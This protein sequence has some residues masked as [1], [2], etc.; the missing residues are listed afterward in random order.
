VRP[1]M[2][3]YIEAERLILRQFTENDTEELHAICN[4]PYILRWMPDWKSS[5]DQRKEWISWV[6]KQYSKTTRETVR[7][8]L[9]VILKSNA[10]LIG[11]IGI[12]NKEEV[13]KE[14]EI[15]YFISEEYC[16]NGYI[17]EAAK[18]MVEWVFTNLKLDYLIAI[19][20]PDNIPS[21]RV[22]E[23]CGFTKLETK[24][25]LNSGEYEEKPFYY[26]RMY[27]ETSYIL[28]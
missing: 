24:M 20:E 9:A 10:K 13:Q 22:V 7:I 8:M 16:N 18:T 1:R 28:T 26:Y 19:V 4:Q 23:K 2:S 14:V 3:I 12:G 5:V 15:A 6:E 21:Q 27:N 11:M 17:S 25:I